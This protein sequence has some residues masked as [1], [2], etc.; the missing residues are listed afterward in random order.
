MNNRRQRR[1]GLEELKDDPNAGGAGKLASLLQGRRLTR[2][3]EIPGADIPFVW[4]VLSGADKQACLGDACAR[5]QK[6]GIP[7]ELR[8]HNDLEDE[9]VWQIIARGMRDPDNV[10]RQLAPV[11]ECRENLTVDQRDILMSEY[12][13]LEEECDPDPINVPAL[14]FEEVQAALKKQPEEAARLLSSFGSRALV[15]Y[16]LSTASQQLSLQ[17]GSSGIASSSGEGTSEPNKLQ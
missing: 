1:P 8:S 9:T 16:L 5:F 2:E 3:S 7:V 6:L 4:R 11:D 13:D 15:S 12:M 10:E 14:W 17:L